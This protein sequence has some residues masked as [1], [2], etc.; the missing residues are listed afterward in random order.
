MKPPSF[1]F[2]TTVIRTSDLRKGFP[3]FGVVTGQRGD[4]VVVRWHVSQYGGHHRHGHKSTLSAASLSV[5][6]DEI[7]RA[8]QT[9]YQARLDQ[10]REQMSRAREGQ[11]ES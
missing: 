11:D 1:A 7:Q 5:T 8:V 3:I 4:R 6:T 10:L 2:G 9:R